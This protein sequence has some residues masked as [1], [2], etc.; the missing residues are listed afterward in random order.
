MRAWREEG[1]QQRPSHP[2][3]ALR[4]PASRCVTRPRITWHVLRAWAGQLCGT[5]QESPATS[6]LSHAASNTMVFPEPGSGFGLAG[7]RWA[8]VEGAGRLSVGGC[9][10]CW[11]WAGPPP[12]PQHCPASPMRQP[13]PASLGRPGRD[14]AL[15]RPPS[16]PS[17]PQLMGKWADQTV[18]ARHG[19][20]ECMRGPGH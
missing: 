11:G 1:S 10:L 4:L 19:V 13:L 8:F 5:S 6:N 15:T 14:A 12:A 16:L 17:Q 2:H 20:T 18:S 9:G 7:P 3:P